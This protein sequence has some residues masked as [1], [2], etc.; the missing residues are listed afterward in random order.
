VKL[1]QQ[2]EHLL[3]EVN[4]NGKGLPEGWNKKS[5]SLGY[6]LIQS[7]V[8]KMK[9]EIHIKNE[10]GTKVQMIFTKYKLTT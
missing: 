8:Q 7:F 2:Q 9:A 6:Q 5:S 1:K 3:L 4:D 10:N